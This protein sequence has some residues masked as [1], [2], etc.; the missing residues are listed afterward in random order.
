MKIGVIGAMGV[1]VASLRKTIDNVRTVKKSTLVFYEGSIRNVPAVVVQ[2]GVGK[3]NAAMCTAMLIGDFEVTH[4]INT[5]IAGGL[6]SGL[7]VFDVVVSSDAVHHD[8]DATGFNY[9]PCEIPGMGT[10]S[11]KADSFLIDCT[12]RA[13]EQ[14]AFSSKLTEGR[15]ASGDVFVNSAERKTQIKALCDPVCVEME[16][17]A[18][19]QVCTLNHTPF[20]IIRSISDMAENT[21]EVYE[22]ELAAHISA[23]LVA[24][25]FEL[26]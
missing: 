18:V 3:V 20:V 17:A 19:A 15:I 1:E 25:M 7:H 22:E 4:V 26:L 13:W 2:C 9:K 11:F 21:G 5:G 14:C 6:Q 24:R 23:S 8:F 16:G 10:V 12:K